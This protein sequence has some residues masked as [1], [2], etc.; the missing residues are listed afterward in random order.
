MGA[1]RGAIRICHVTEVRH[2]TEISADGGSRGHIFCLEQAL[3]LEN[4]IRPPASIS[5]WGRLL[6]NLSDL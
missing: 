1:G 2:V 6:S 4:C 3:G 5:T